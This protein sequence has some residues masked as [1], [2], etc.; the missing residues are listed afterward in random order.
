MRMMA[1]VH[2][3]SCHRSVKPNLRAPHFTCYLSAVVLTQVSIM[4]IINKNRTTITRWETPESLIWTP[5]FS[6]KGVIKLVLHLFTCAVKPAHQ[7]MLP[8]ICPSAGERN[9]ARS[10]YQMR[11]NATETQ[12][13]IYSS[14]KLPPVFSHG[15]LRNRCRKS[16]SHQI[17]QR[18]QKPLQ[19]RKERWQMKTK[20]CNATR[21]WK[22]GEDVGAV[23]VLHYRTSS[24]AD[25]R[26]GEGS[27][28]C[29]S[30]L[31][32]SGTGK[33]E[34][35]SSVHVL[36]FFL[37]FISVRNTGGQQGSLQTQPPFMA[38]DIYCA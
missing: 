8:P 14:K 7:N 26:E 5:T 12:G 13:E 30:A 36:F 32:L 18:N 24:P 29:S 11:R 35:V 27:I 33:T 38:C 9:G 15:P 23:S 31:S 10:I 22:H 19:Q 16:L 21:K 1:W 20:C 3:S 25:R 6:H 4:Y 28:F 2:L 34:N 37:I 17:S